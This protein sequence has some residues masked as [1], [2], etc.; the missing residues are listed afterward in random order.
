M[1]ATED[2]GSMACHGCARPLVDGA[3]PVVYW[4]GEAYHFTCWTRA[5]IVRASDD[6]DPPPQEP[7]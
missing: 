6:P 5:P 1:A 4:E 7:T 2:P 3:L